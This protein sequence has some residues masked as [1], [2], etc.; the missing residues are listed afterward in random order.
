MRASLRLH[1]VVDHPPLLQ[2]AMDPHD[3]PYIPSHVPAACC[4]CEVLRRIESEAV[5]HEVTICNV[6]VCVYGGGGGMV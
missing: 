2:K 1:M 6:A 4:H 5:H 3:G